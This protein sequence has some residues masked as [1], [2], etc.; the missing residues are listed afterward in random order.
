MSE[1]PEMISSPGLANSISV[2]LYWAS[3]YDWD[4]LHKKKYLSGKR[5]SEKLIALY[6]REDIALG[7]GESVGPFLFCWSLLIREWF[8]SKWEAWTG[9]TFGQIFKLWILCSI[10]LIFLSGKNGTTFGQIF[11]L[12]ILCSN[13][14]LFF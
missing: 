9:W 3:I 10:F 12:L 6:L 11:K 2:T 14:I 8:H 1:S 13:W 5:I 7:W 4:H